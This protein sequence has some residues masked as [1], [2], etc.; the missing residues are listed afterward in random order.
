ML[1]ENCGVVQPGEYPPLILSPPQLARDHSH[2]LRNEIKESY[3]LIHGSLEVLA[4]FI[5]LLI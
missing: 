3:G 1:K 4:F 5:P 2:R